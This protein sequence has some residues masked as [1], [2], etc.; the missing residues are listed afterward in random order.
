MIGFF[1]D[2]PNSDIWEYTCAV[3]DP[4]DQNYV[5]LLNWPLSFGCWGCRIR[6]EMRGS[7]RIT[8][9]DLQDDSYRRDMRYLQGVA[10]E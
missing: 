5:Y 4:D 2:G 7:Q 6:I 9:Y 3:I 10:D 8:W 1:E